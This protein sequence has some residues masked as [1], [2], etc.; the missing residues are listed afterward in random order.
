[1]SKPVS[2]KLLYPNASAWELAPGKFYLV[3]LR[4]EQVSVE[5]LTGLNKR[6]RAKGI[7]GIALSLSAD[8]ELALYEVDSNAATITICTEE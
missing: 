7:N 5:D 1:M 4:G 8:A 6:L 3:V 2:L